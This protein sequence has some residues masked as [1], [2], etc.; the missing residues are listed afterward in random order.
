M[1]SWIKNF[2][3]QTRDTSSDTKSSAQDDIFVSLGERG[4]VLKR[5]DSIF[6]EM[7]IPTSNRIP[8]PN[9]TG[10]ILVILVGFK[11]VSVIQAGIINA[12]WSQH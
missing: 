8:S 11:V 6:D 12:G 5:F 4:N 2:S 9:D 10:P 7:S 3:R 1:N